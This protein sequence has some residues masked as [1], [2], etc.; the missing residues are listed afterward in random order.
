[1]AHIEDQDSDLSSPLPQRTTFASRKLGQLALARQAMLVELEGGRAALWNL[2]PE[3]GI[4]SIDSCSSTKSLN[5]TSLRKLGASPNKCDTRRPSEGTPKEGVTVA[6]N[7]NAT[8]DYS[9]GRR[10]EATLMNT[11]RDTVLSNSEPASIEL[12][13][14]SREAIPE[15]GNI[16]PRRPLTARGSLCSGVDEKA[17]AAVAE[18]ARRQSSEAPSI[19]L[20]TNRPFLVGELANRIQQQTTPP[21]HTPIIPTSPLRNPSTPTSTSTPHKEIGKKAPDIRVLSKLLFFGGTSPQKAFISAQSTPEAVTPDVTVYPQSRSASTDSFHQSY[22]LQLGQIMGGLAQEKP[23]QRNARELDETAHS[24]TSTNSSLEHLVT[25]K[26]ETPRRVKRSL[27]LF[28]FLIACVSSSWITFQYGGCV[29]STLD[30]MKKVKLVPFGTQQYNNAVLQVDLFL[31]KTAWTAVYPKTIN[32]IYR[33]IGQE[34]F[35]AVMQKFHN[36]DETN[37]KLLPDARQRYNSTVRLVKLF[38]ERT[39]WT[40]VYTKT[41]NWI[42]GNIGWEYDNIGWENVWVATQKCHL[43]SMVAALDSANTTAK[44]LSPKVHGT[45]HIQWSL[46]SE[47]PTVPTETNSRRGVAPP[48]PAES[49]EANLGTS[50]QD[51]SDENPLEQA[52]NEKP[53]Q[54]ALYRGSLED[55]AMTRVTLDTVEDYSDDAQ[56]VSHLN[57]V[58]SKHHSNIS[59]LV[60][61][62]QSSFW[63]SNRPGASFLSLESRHDNTKLLPC[64]FSDVIPNQCHPST[65]ANLCC[66]SEFFARENSATVPRIINDV[67]SFDLEEDDGFL[68]IPLVDIVGQFLRERRKKKQRKLPRQ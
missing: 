65:S 66:I 51:S 10:R 15:E 6:S 40:E 55:G 49:E 7:A 38:L 21:S 57:S 46:P 5:L 27:R 54:D 67:L 30:K 36:F 59:C 23:M 32:W 68:Q 9:S 11:D 28:L 44:I 41:A 24:N 19:V 16:R 62:V 1:M 61:A 37:V 34:H 2:H 22:L 33:N 31:G 42:Y 20:P 17:L 14:P 63:K 60:T 13:A 4:R 53:T 64:F 56:Q 12:G 48:K 58:P 45:P 39:A 43:T 3:P 52:T 29:F 47:I 26:R 8:H 18:L 25:E 35:W 50:P